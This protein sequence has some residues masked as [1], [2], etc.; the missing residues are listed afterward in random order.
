MATTTGPFEP[1]GQYTPGLSYV[2]IVAAWLAFCVSFGLPATNVLSK[3]G[4][5]P[6]TPLLGWDAFLTSVLIIPAQP[7]LVLADPQV[8]LFLAFPVLNFAMA[9]MPWFVLSHPEKARSYGAALILLGLVPWTLP[10]RLT[11]DLFLGF[12]V[13]N[14]SCFAMAAGCIWFGME[15]GR[16]LRQQGGGC[17][18]LAKIGLLWNEKLQ[19][20]SDKL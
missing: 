4:T 16:Y 10:K 13:W 7:L 15:R 12:Y 9:G 3:G 5:E 17:E 1:R 18:D 11:G 14:L 2:P 19:S 20:D 6:G 8:L